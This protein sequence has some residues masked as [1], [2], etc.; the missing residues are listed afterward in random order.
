MIFLAR[1]VLLGIVG[2]CAGGIVAGGV[3][4]LITT[5][6]IIVKLAVKSHTFTTLKHYENCMII[7]VLVA[8]TF[9]I[10]EPHM[11]V[12]GLAGL[13]LLG[14]IG[15]FIGMFVGCIALSLAEALDVSTIFFRRI[16]LN[17]NIKYVILAAAAGKVIGNAIYFLK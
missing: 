8:N 14:F 13:I 11:K 2:L 10:Y 16:G 15:L 17:K 12:K 9:Y 5:M 3:C 4:A 7:G 6:G 1:N